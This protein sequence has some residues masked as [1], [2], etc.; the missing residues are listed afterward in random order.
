MF[1]TFVPFQFLR[2]EN[3]SFQPFRYELW[4][5]GKMISSGKTNHI[6]EAKVIRSEN[7]EKVEINFNDTAL[8]NEIAS[9]NVF[10]EFITG[11]DRLQLVTIPKQTN[12][13]FTGLNTL[14]MFVG[15]TRLMKD[16]NRNEPYCCNLFLQQDYIVKIT[17]S[18]S[19]PE[20]LLEFYSGDDIDYTPNE[21]PLLKMAKKALN[22]IQL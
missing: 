14:Q 20:K 12:S 22:D 16:F 9:K 10:D 5:G 11:R 13:Q 4:M 8:H 15:T 7:I 2:K 18:Y 17:F 1:D 3:F 21:N 6:I 19:N